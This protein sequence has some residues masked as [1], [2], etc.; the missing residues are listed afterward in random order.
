MGYWKGLLRLFLLLYD[1]NCQYHVNLFKRL[2]ESQA[3]QEV[4]DLDD[5]ELKFGIGLFHV[6]GHSNECYCRFAPTFIPGAGLID[7]ELIETLWDPLNHISGSIRAMSYFHRWEILDLHMNDSN[8]KKLLRMGQCLNGYSELQTDATL[9]SAIIRKYR[10]AVAGAKETKEEY[11][12]LADLPS[13]AARKDEWLAEEANAQ[14]KRASDMKNVDAMDIF[15][16]A[17][18]EGRHHCPSITFEYSNDSVVPSRAKVMQALVEK[19]A[20]SEVGAAAWITDGMKI[21]ETQ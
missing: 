3:L 10:K 4:L 7:G 21:Q 19:E 13:I 15:E 20:G 6:H 9:V 17:E 14:A 16:V 2:R 8:W 18:D 11:D 12:R 1:I 5:L